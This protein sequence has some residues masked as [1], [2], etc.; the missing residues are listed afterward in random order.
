MN[1]TAL[2]YIFFA[3]LSA[4]GVSAINFDGFIK[5]GKVWEARVLAMILIFALGYLAAN[6]V[7]DFVGVTKIS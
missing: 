7:I 6:F 5:K 2:I 1:Y 4:Y 3:F